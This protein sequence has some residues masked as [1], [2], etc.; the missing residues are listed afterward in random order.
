MKTPVKTNLLL[1]VAFSLALA[2]AAVFAVNGGDV[3]AR[4]PAP[5]PTPSPVPTPTPTPL[6]TPPGFDVR[7]SRLTETLTAIAKSAPGNMGIAVFDPASETHVSIHGDKAFPLANTYQLA[8]ALAAFHLAD[9][10][11]LRLDQLIPIGPAEIR[12][13]HSPIAD[14][15]PQGNVS[16]PLWKLVRSVL[17]DG[18]T[19][20][21]DLVMRLIGD[22][23]DVQNVLNNDKL[24]GFTIRKTQADLYQDAIDK[25]TFAKGGDNAGTPD[26]LAA[27]LLGAADLKDLSLDSTT[28]FVLDLSEAHV[29]DSRLRAGLPAHAGFAH[30]SGSTDPYDGT[31]DATNDAGL[32]LLP[33]GHRIAIVVMLS[34]STADASTRDALFATIGKAVY[35]AFVP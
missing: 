10:R 9:E 19:T 12:R 21:S 20:A 14:Q 33:D 11:K 13:G 26:G 29:G 4:R 18:D 2:C 6:P 22:P 17:A 1:R 32:L 31:T 7:M 25:R 27:L 24:A 28:E 30:K 35:T 23:S 34:E 8:L 3:E 15:Y 16:L 5:T